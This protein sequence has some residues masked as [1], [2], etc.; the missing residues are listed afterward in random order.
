MA[1]RPTFY[2]VCFPAIQFC[3]EKNFGTERRIICQ[4]S[5]S[6]EG[7]APDKEICHL[8]RKTKIRPVL[9]NVTRWSS[10]FTMVQR[11]V[12][13]LPFID[14]EDE[15]LAPLLPG[16]QEDIEIKNILQTMI[17]LDSVTKKLQCEKV[18][19]F[20]VRIIFDKIMEDFEEVEH[21]LGA[22]NGT[23]THN[24]AFEKAIIKTIAGENLTFLEKYEIDS[25]VKQDEAAESTSSSS[26][27]Y[28]D[29]II[30]SKKAKKMIHFEW[31]P[32]TSN[33]CER[34]FSRAK[35]IFDDYRKKLEPVNLES[36]LFLFVT[37]QLWDIKIVSD[38]V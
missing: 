26:T 16:P 32:A 36:Q 11:Y 30:A 20:D 8:K 33:V 24:P 35:M 38:L 1:F 22:G 21:F 15:D 13:L 17:K 4:N 10:T 29:E 31:I 28:V 18:N 27:S 7:F 19:L 37:K 25:F 14:R 34:L 3:S 12:D 23:L 5:D 9:R 2:W 6:Y